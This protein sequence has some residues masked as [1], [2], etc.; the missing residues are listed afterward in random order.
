VLSGKAVRL[1][2]VLALAQL[3]TSVAAL[4]TAAAA[5]IKLFQHDRVL[6]E[7]NTTVQHTAK[8]TEVAAAR[9]GKALDEFDAHMTALGAAATAFAAMAAKRPDG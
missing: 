9:A 5:V 4:L 1:V 6:K 3:I 8:T 7:T 2:G